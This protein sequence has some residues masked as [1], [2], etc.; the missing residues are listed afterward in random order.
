[1]GIILR[2]SRVDFGQKMGQALIKCH[3]GFGRCLQ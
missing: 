3:D 2:E 1:M